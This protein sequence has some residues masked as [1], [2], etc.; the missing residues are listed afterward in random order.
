MSQ[1]TPDAV[2]KRCRMLIKSYG[3]EAVLVMRKGD[4]ISVGLAGLASATNAP[5]LRP[6]ECFFADMVEVPA[7]AAL[8]HLMS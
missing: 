2:V 5:V 6:S 3:D 1:H 8:K 4:V 7:E